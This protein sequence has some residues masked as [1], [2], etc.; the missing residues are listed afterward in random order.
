M[1][2]A[3][4]RAAGQELDAV[5]EDLVAQ[6]DVDDTD[7]AVA[8]L[9]SSREGI[10]TLIFGGPPHGARVVVEQSGESRLTF[11]QQWGDVPA[12]IE[13]PGTDNRA[14]DMNTAARPTF[15]GIQITPVHLPEHDPGGVAFCGS[16]QISSP[17][18]IDAHGRRELWHSYQQQSE[19]TSV[20]AL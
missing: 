1:R 13:P 11:P 8:A 15:R 10:A 16:W 18:A 3:V 4:V 9:A 19:K 17:K 7:A 5:D 14:I 20:P 12:S 2:E 6:I